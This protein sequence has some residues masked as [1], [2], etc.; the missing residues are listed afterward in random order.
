MW[1]VNA[2]A[3]SYIVDT[4]FRWI[5]FMRQFIIAFVLSICIL[6]RCAYSLTAFSSGRKSKIQLVYKGDDESIHSVGDLDH[7]VK[8]LTDQNY[9][10][11]TTDKLSYMPSVVGLK[12]EDQRTM[13]HY[14]AGT[15]RPVFLY[16][17]LKL[18]PNDIN[19]RDED[20]RTPL[21][22][23]CDNDNEHD[24][25]EKR[26]CLKLFQKY[27][28]DFTAEDNNQDTILHYTAES[29]YNLDILPDL[30]QA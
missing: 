29:R 13:L 22:H 19:A 30:L 7:F 27:G 5:P 28:A 11:S 18:S 16:E 14:V 8:M 10:Y 25:E 23:F 17:A 3:I 24:N 9:R 21:L 4:K 20:G 15:Q 1:T 6:Q 2:T 12:E 26:L